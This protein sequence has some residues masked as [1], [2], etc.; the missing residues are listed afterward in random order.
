[1]Q[2]WWD[3]TSNFS[4]FTSKIKLNIAGQPEQ[5]P[6]ASWFI[7]LNNTFKLPK[8]FS[9]QLSGEYNSKTI[10]PPGGS[11]GGGSRG[12]MFGGGGGTAYVPP[13]GTMTAGQVGGYQF[14]GISGLNFLG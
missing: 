10:L 5:D 6:F 9:I 13:V 7:K 14:P 8:N 11:G 3:L 2:K 12:G 4:L 1:M